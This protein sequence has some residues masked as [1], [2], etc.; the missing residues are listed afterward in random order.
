MSILVCL[1]I[2]LRP[3]ENISLEDIKIACVGLRPMLDTYD[4]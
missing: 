1:C 4:H 3:F 2:V